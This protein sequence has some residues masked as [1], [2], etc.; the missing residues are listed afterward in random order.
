MKRESSFKA[1]HSELTDPAE[2]LPWDSALTNYS[3]NHAVSR[4]C[5]I[6]FFFKLI[7]RTLHDPHPQCD[8]EMQPLSTPSALFTSKK[9]NILEALSVPDSDY[10]DLSPKGSVDEGIRR[11]IDEINVIDGL[12]TTSSCAGRV[13]VFLE[14]QKT[15]EAGQEDGQLATPG[16]KGGGGAWLFVSHDPVS[17]NGWVDGLE[18]SE[19]DGK[20]VISA[21]RRLIHFKF[22]PMVKEAP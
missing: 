14:G 20:S 4:S 5:F 2:G 11:L 8:S 9:T 17:G 13:S 7:T 15:L 1:H 6:V 21:A 12:V 16:G 3:A 10:T 22:E 19:E 18:M